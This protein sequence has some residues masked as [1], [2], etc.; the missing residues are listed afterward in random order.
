M[1]EISQPDLMTALTYLMTA[2]AGVGASLVMSFIE[3]LF[4]PISPLTARQKFYTSM[5]LSFACPMVVYLL[6][7]ALGWQ[8]LTLP[9]VLAELGVGFAV[10]QTVHFEAKQAAIPAAQ[11]GGND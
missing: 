10:S 1:L 8:A 5:G 2:G 9:G 6:V 11:E 7:I 4:D 3:K